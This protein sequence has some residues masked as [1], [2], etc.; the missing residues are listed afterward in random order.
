MESYCACFFVEML[1]TFQYLVCWR[2][3]LENLQL[4]SFYVSGALQNLRIKKIIKS[5]LQKLSL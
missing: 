5:Q 2:F 3:K 4:V 1:Q